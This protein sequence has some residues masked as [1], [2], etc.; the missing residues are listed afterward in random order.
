MLLFGL[1]S[2]FWLC[3]VGWWWDGLISVVLVGFRCV[4]NWGLI[5]LLD[6]VR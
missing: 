3:W 4:G 1:L 2:S 6:S 5:V